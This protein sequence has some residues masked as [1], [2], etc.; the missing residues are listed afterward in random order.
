MF[1]FEQLP[2]LTPSPTSGPRRLRGLALA[3][4]AVLA[5]VGTGACD[6]SLPEESAAEV[7]TT[8]TEPVEVVPQDTLVPPAPED[9]VPPPVS[10]CS[11]GAIA[12]DL[13]MNESAVSG[14]E[15]HDG[16]AEAAVC[17]AAD[18]MDCI[19]STRILRVG[20]GRWTDVDAIL[21]GCVES[22]VA[23][24]M[25][26][27]TALKFPGH[28]FCNPPPT[29]SAATSPDC[30]EAAIYET[31][32]P[33]GNGNFSIETLHCSGA[34]AT[35]TGVSGKGIPREHLLVWDGRVWVL[36]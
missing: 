27:E 9:T 30:S 35:V 4:A 17:A 18:P 2:C 20:D 11:A 14:V 22:H 32:D 13:G 19:D 31:L 15:C 7:S 24:G 26:A 3:L 36:Q 23:A 28:R 5:V 6:R 29:E 12:T 33:K 21:T 1:P 8:S 34:R 10:E 25:P 16:W